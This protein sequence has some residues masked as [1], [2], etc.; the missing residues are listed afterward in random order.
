MPVERLLLLAHFVIRQVTEQGVDLHRQ[1]IMRLKHLERMFVH[2]A[3]HI[4]QPAAGRIEMP[5]MRVDGAQADGQQR[6]RDR[7]QGKD[8]QEARAG[9]DG[10]SVMGTQ[11]EP[12][13]RA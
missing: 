3:D 10:A 9:E 4:G 2:D 6:H 1:Q 13:R 11:R 12:A 5:V 7:K 8:P